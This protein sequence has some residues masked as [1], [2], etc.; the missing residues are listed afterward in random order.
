MGSL[1]KLI[2][3]F[4]R[5]FGRELDSLVECSVSIHEECLLLN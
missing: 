3:M 5:A 1:V 4:G 2:S